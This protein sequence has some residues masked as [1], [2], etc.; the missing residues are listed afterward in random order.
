MLIRSLKAAPAHSGHI[1]AMRDCHTLA[2]IVG[3]M[4][5]TQIISER[6]DQL[7]VGFEHQRNQHFLAFQ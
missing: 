5:G 2:L 6:V 4:I 3:A 1:E 7:C